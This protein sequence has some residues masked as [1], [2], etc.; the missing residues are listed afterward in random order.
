MAD[1]RYVQTTA[2]GLSVVKKAPTD[3][4]NQQPESDAK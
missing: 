4:D 2:A 1:D 3:K